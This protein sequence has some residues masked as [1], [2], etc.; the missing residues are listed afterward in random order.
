MK[1]ILKIYEPLSPITILKHREKKV[2]DILSTSFFLS[3]IN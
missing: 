1:N 3:Q 2:K